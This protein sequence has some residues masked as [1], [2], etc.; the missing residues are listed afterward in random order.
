MKTLNLKLQGGY[1]IRPA[2]EIDGQIIPYKRNK[3]QSTM[4]TFQT[5]KE[6][7]DI[8]IKNILEINGP[9]WWFMQMFFFIISIF[10]ILNPRLGKNCYIVDYQATIDL[11]NEQN[12]VTLKF[13]MTKD[14]EKAIDVLSEAKPKDEKS[15]LY[16]LDQTA[17]KRKKILKISYI[18]SWIVLI[19]IVAIIL[20]VVL[21]K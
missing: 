19:I 12:D 1:E 11:P 20:F 9:W 13:N 18:I 14:G 21:K 4:I 15:N 10:G 8:K 2:I 7:V 5:E 17:K 3:H 6:C 16:T